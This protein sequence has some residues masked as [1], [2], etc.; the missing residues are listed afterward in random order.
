MLLL[1][2]A[3]EFSSLK[4]L[5][6]WSHPVT[7]VAIISVLLAWAGVCILWCTRVLSFSQRTRQL[8][9]ILDKKIFEWDICARKMT[10][11]RDSGEYTSL[12]AHQNK[13][14]VTYDWYTAQIEEKTKK[15]G[16]AI[17]ASAWWTPWFH[18]LRIRCQNVDTSPSKY[19]KS[20]TVRKILMKYN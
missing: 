9:A 13:N 2:S 6:T 7:M 3:Y 11:H 16:V 8:I 5:I 19:G 12:S 10:V 1:L 14:L 4:Q 17:I 20:D 15:Q 18:H